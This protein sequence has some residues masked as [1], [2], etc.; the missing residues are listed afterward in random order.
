[1]SG[2][3]RWLRTRRRQLGALVCL[4][5]IVGAGMAYSRRALTAPQAAISGLPDVVLP[6]AGQ[7]VL[8]FAPH[9]DDETIAAGGYISESVGRKARVR[10]VLVTDGNKHHLETVRYREFKASARTLGVSESELIFLNYPDGKLERQNRAG[11]YAVLKKQIDDYDPDIVIYPHLG[12]KHPDHAISGQLVKAALAHSARR[13]IGYRYL[14][15]HEGFPR[16]RKYRPELYILPPRGPVGVDDWGRLML[17]ENAEAAKS[18]ALFHYRT[19]LRV[20]GL[21]SLLL[22]CV[23]RNELFAADPENA[24][25]QGRARQGP[26]TGGATDTG[27]RPPREAGPD[28]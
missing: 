21:R 28:H 16:P 20:P 2:L 11:V 25:A 1:M 18:E 24:P 12:D 8:V 19:Q 26:H 9:P 7:R 27:L 15:H 6:T 17:T 13:R 22:S 23:R 3:G 14:V 5:A 4:I 10:I